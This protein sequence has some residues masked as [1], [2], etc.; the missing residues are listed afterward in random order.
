MFH[1]NYSRENIFSKTGKTLLQKGNLNKK[2]SPHLFIYLRRKKK[3]SEVFFWNQK[4]NCQIEKT[5][6]CVKKKRNAKIFAKRSILNAQLF[7]YGG[8]MSKTMG[9]FEMGCLE[10]WVKSL[11][12]SEKDYHF[13][14]GFSNHKIQIAPL[15][16]SKRIATK[17]W[18]QIQ[19]NRCGPD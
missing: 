18:K 11:G 13:M 7:F 8:F 9:K 16:E 12:D 17:V 6:F 3:M 4:L 10:P 14:E 15:R 19:R 2:V 5:A 1:Q